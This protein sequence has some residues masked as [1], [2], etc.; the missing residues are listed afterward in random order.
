MNSTVFLRIFHF[1]L[2]CLGIIFLPYLS[3]AYTL[4]FLAFVFL[5]VLLLYVWFL[6]FLYAVDFVCLLVACLL[7]KER[8]KWEALEESG[9]GEI[10]IKIYC[11]NK[12]FFSIK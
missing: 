5:Y 4:L 7:S 2:L 11:T 3:F 9:R 10:L 6:C 1:I 12:I 8:K